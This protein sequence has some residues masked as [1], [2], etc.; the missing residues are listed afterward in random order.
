M[1][2][3][4]C[5]NCSGVT[6]ENDIFMKI[7][8]ACSEFKRHRRRLLDVL[9]LEVLTHER[10][11]A[12]HKMANLLDSN[13]DLLLVLSTS[14]CGEPVYAEIRGCRDIIENAR[15]HLFV[16]VTSQI[17]LPDEGVSEDVCF[18]IVVA[19]CEGVLASAGREASHT[20][21]HCTHPDV[22]AMGCVPFNTVAVRE[23]T[24]WQL[25]CSMS[26]LV[27]HRQN[28]NWRCRALH[29]YIL[30]LQRRACIV[31]N[32]HMLN[33][34]DVRSF[35]VRRAQWSCAI[36][37]F[38]NSSLHAMQLAQAVHRTDTDRFRAWLADTVTK[39]DGPRLRE[40]IAHAYRKR[41][42]RIDEIGRNRAFGGQGTL[43]RARSSL[44][45]MEEL[46]HSV[47]LAA[48]VM[49]PE[50]ECVCLMRTL[51]DVTVM[52]IFA[53]CLELVEIDFA[54]NHIV[55]DSLREMWAA[56]NLPSQNEVRP[57]YICETMGGF[58]IRGANSDTVEFHSFSAAALAWYENFLGNSDPLKIQLH[59]CV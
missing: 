59:S 36:A 47:D 51:Q 1:E 3:C 8:D 43:E 16:H 31:V 46:I 6:E 15:I 21:G 28:I 14:T 4:I 53:N 23:M 25:D 17:L 11:A 35:E 40:S 52:K 26:C 24:P 42:I 12:L 56:D 5:N 10:L 2:S 50:S 48:L 55:L 41:M 49:L 37:V 45:I 22:T 30:A 38:K 54:S 29:G 18:F 57:L 7:R 39:W 20:A 13:E 27:E 34:S 9:Q 58:A 44:D 32:N 19:A 33:K